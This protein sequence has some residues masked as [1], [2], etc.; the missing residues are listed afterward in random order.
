MVGVREG[1]LALLAR[2]PRHGYQL[3]VEFEH[4][5]GEV[6]PINVGQIYSTLQR[7]ERDGSVEP[8]AEDEEGRISYRLTRD[9]LEELSAWF[10][11]PVD[12]SVPRRDELSM[13][14]L[15]ALVAGV[16]DPLEV[17]SV[18]RTSTMRALQ[19]YTRFKADV[20]VQDLA[21]ALQLDRLIMLAEAELRWLERVEE[22]LSRA[23]MDVG[24]GLAEGEQAEP[25]ES[26]DEGRG[27][28]G[29]ER[30]R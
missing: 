6:W 17:L 25:M 24:P 15:L 20:D 26:R 23:G 28:L 13:K 14:L 4:A 30:Q 16:K 21:W 7:L 10:E 9:G 1:L 22:R 3:K 11:T 12:R 27:V 2:G 5:T 18:Q 8:E 19:D 29:G